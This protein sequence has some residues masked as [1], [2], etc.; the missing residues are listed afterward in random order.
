[1]SG[2][3]KGKL[4]VIRGKERLDVGL[5]ED[6]FLLQAVF[7]CMGAGPNP[8]CRAP[9]LAPLRWQN[10]IPPSDHANRP[11]RIPPAGRPC[12]RPSAVKTLCHR[13]ATPTVRSKSRLPAAHVGASPLAKPYATVGPRQQAGPNPAR[14]PSMLAPLRRQ[15]LMPPLGHANRPSQIPPGSRPCWRPSAG[16]TLSHRR[17]TPTGRPKSRLPAAHVG[18]PPPAKPHLTVGPRQQSGPN[19]ACR[20]PMLAPPRWQNLMP[21]SGHANRPAQIPPAGLL[22]WSGS[23]ATPFYTEIYK[24]TIFCLHLDR[25]GLKNSLPIKTVLK[26]NFFY[27]IIVL[28]MESCNI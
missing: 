22:A 24:P 3:A 19:P 14:Q 16:K 17:T 25:Y 5:Q 21:P 10:L 23:A 26:G 13:R 7:Y 15:R 20:P 1:M 12:W 11:A 8:D 6:E 2:R 9:M 18:A 28:S 27:E 4:F